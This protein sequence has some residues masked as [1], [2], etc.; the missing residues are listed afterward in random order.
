MNNV[1]VCSKCNNTKV[2]N[3]DEARYVME[4]LRFQDEIDW[5]IIIII[6]FMAFI[7]T[8]YFVINIIGY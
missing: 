5:L 8:I 3:N 2:S 4:I 1:M 7:I 6:L